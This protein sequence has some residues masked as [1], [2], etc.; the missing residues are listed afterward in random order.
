MKILAL[1]PLALI[2]M[3]TGC[4]TSS[5]D[6]FDF[7]AGTWTTVKDGLS[8]TM[9]VT[10]VAKSNEWIEVQYI[11]D[12]RQGQMQV[13]RFQYDPSADVWTK[14]ISLS[15]G[16]IS[17]FVGTVQ[18][19]ERVILEQVSYGERLFD[20]PQSRV[21]YTP[22]DSARFELDWQ[23][24]KE[25]GTWMARPKP[26]TYQRVERPDA[27]TEEGR[28]AFI[29]NREDNWEVYTMNPDGSDV[30]N[31]TNH[32]AGD[33]FP[34]WIAGGS[35]LAFRSQRGRDDGGW[36][37]WEIDIDGTDAAFVDMPGRLNN[38]DAGTFPEV[39]PSGSYLVNAAEREG[40]QDIYIWRYDGGGERVVAPAQGLDYRPLFSPDGEKILFISER[41]GN[42]EVY[43]VAF[44]GS[45]VQRLTESPG[46]DRYARWSPS[47][48]QI[49]FV[50]D[51]DGDLE[52]YVMDVDGANV[53]Q[54]T[55][56]DAEDGEISWSP[57]GTH[58]AF[59][60][61]VSGNGDINVV[62]LETGKIVNLTNNDAY[63]GEPIWSPVRP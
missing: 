20:P 17:Q 23:T 6:G 53:R 4:T 9:E 34:R 49:G 35:R 57:S 1:L 36:D 3:L 50:S 48:N 2:I 25:D 10:H 51:R 38:P 29:S 40:E 19:D 7:L 43:T 24:R 28:I 42:A 31:I 8:L 47:G 15:D 61:D 52:V 30:R 58:I 46:I 60:S 12:N 56:N 32:D 21:V 33:H 13:T 16:I 27:P 39:H 63:D 55:F 54:L 59:R 14:T 45:D 26:F 37:R 41:D 62:N 22:L 5:S 11:D 18:E 44:D